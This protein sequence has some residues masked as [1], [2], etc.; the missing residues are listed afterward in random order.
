MANH[1]II[2]NVNEKLNTH[3]FGQYKLNFICGNDVLHFGHPTGIL[4]IIHRKPVKGRDYSTADIDSIIELIDRYDLVFSLTE[5][6]VSRLKELGPRVNF[7]IGYFSFCKGACY[8]YIRKTIYL[9]PSRIFRRWNMHFKNSIDLSHF[10]T[11]LILHELGHVLQDQE[12]PRITRL[13]QFVSGFNHFRVSNQ[14][15]EKYKHFLMHEEKDAW[16]RCEKYLCG[17]TIAPSSFSK[18]KAY[19]LSTYA[20]LELTRVKANL[21]ALFHDVHLKKGLLE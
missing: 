13:K 11:I 1:L 14:D 9:N 18:I 15:A 6:S 8:N 12:Q 7:E 3:G 4:K 16:D 5:L 21:K 17:T 20:T 10:I 19:C 2:K